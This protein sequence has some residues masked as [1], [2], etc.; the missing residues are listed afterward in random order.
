MVEDD[1]VAVNSHV[2]GPDHAAIVG[3]MDG[4]GLSVGEIE[5]EV[6]LLVDLIAV[7]DVVAD[8]GEI[9]LFLA[10]VNEGAVPQDLFFSL[11]AQVGEL[12]VVDAA[13]FAVDLEEAGQ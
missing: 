3:G 7:V 2:A 6:H 9:G 5:A 11:E 12:L 4:S 1:A 13:E 8:V 10:P